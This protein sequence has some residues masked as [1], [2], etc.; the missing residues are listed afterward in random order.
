ML[1]YSIQTNRNRKKFNNQ[2]ERREQQQNVDTQKT[3]VLF[4]MEFLW[5]MRE[6]CPAHP[7]Y[8]TANMAR[9][10]E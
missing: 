6:V 5:I 2:P 1:Y 4:L 8:F 3:S 9:S 7:Y 10:Q